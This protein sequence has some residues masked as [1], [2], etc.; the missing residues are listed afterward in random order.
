MVLMAEHM[1]SDGNSIWAL[2]RELE[3]VRTGVA[4]KILAPLDLE[5]KRPA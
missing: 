1:E 5:L 4:P 2:T 3:A